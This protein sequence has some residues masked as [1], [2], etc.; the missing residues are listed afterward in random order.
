MKKEQSNKVE[1]VELDMVRV[2][3][4]INYIKQSQEQNRQDNATEHNDIKVMIKNFI[5]GA[6]KKYAA[7]QIETWFYALCGIIV[8]AVIIAIVELVIV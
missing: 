1:K 8:T 6:D 5:D 7:K 4:D 2:Q 3:T